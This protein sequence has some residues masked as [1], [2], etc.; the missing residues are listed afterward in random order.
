MIQICSKMKWVIPWPML[1]PSTKINENVSFVFLR[2]PSDETNG[3][4]IITFLAEVPIA[5]YFSQVS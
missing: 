1:N 5:K 4:E 2:N 3:T